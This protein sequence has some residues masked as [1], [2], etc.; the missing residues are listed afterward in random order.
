MIQTKTNLTDALSKEK[1]T[2]TITKEQINNNLKKL[3]GNNNI[4]INHTNVIKLKQQ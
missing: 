4:I 3:N 1:S 2:H